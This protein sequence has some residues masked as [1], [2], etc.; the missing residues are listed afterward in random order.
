M[1][2]IILHLVY[3]Y[4]KVM[5]IPLCQ[6]YSETGSLDNTTLMY[7][8]LCLQVR[9]RSRFFTFDMK[10]WNKLAISCS[11]SILLLLFFVLFCFESS[12]VPETRL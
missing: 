6:I 8:R 11:C 10:T 12:F 5:W 3:M 1:V 4:V 9:E 7:I 2:D